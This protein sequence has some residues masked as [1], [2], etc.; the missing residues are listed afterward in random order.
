MNGQSEVGRF[1]D[2]PLRI[3]ILSPPWFPVPPTGYGGIEA[4]VSLL[5]EGLVECGHDV[6]L[7]ASGDSHTRAHLVAAFPDAPSAL[8]GTTAVE[9]RHAIEC[10]VRADRFDVIHDHSGLLAL[11]LGGLTSTPVVH[12]VHGPMDGDHADDYARL[13]P[14]LPNARLISISLNQ[15]RLRPGLPWFANIPNAVDLGGYRLGTEKERYLA[16]VGRMSADK[17]CHLAIEIAAAAGLPL[18]IAGKR[19]E[20]PELAYFAEHVA[21]H[22]GPNVEYLG[23]IPHEAKVDLLRH[24]LA[25]LF[26][27]TW[28]EPFGLVMI[29]SMACGTPVLATRRGAVPEIVEHGVT[30]FVVDHPL[31]LAA[32]VDAAAALDPA[33]LRA[34]AEASFSAER[35]VADHVAVYRA[36]VA[37]AAA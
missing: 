7:F 6:T 9:L 2:A 13:Y 18:R 15:Q 19:R 5:V 14:L 3:A 1:G 23:E 37:L 25:T 22:L 28:E 24:A 36:A 16:F 10:Y 11:A 21:P 32:Y 26:P 31:E 33:T 30:G 20:P 35:L 17:G 8:I 12:T 34:H 29:E 4:V 27:I